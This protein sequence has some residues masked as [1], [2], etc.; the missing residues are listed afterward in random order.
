MRFGSTP[1][2]STSVPAFR[3][4]GRS[5]VTRFA[6]TPT[7]IISASGLPTIDGP[8]LRLSLRRAAK[9]SNGSSRFT[10]SSSLSPRK[11][12]RMRSCF[13]MSRDWIC[14]PQHNKS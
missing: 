5:G 14:T 1:H 10:W 13:W 2:L 7:A 9:A 6:I 8:M 4:G 3:R 11:D 12:T